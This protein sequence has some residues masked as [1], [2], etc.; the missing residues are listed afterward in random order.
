MMTTGRGRST[1]D[2]EGGLM[3]RLGQWLAMVGLILS[4][5]GCGSL[6]LYSKE[7]DVAATSAKSDY[8]ASKVTQ[9]I[10]AEGAM[11]DGLD[12]KEIEAFRKVT[13]AERNL[14]L[15]SLV[16]ESGTSAK[17]S[18]AN[19]LV[20]RFR[21]LADAR[22]IALTGP[23]TDP[24]QFLKELNNRKG[25]LRDA[26]SNEIRAR[27]QLI[28]FHAKFALL[29]ACNQDVAGLKANPSAD[30]AAALTKDA[31]FQ[32][33]NI[34]VSVTWGIAIGNLGAA[35]EALLDARV[36]MAASLQ[37][38]NAAQVGL[39]MSA[40]NDQEALLGRKQ[41]DAKA[42]GAALRSA[43]KA[44]ADARNA[45]QSASQGIDL[46][47]DP[48]KAATPPPAGADEVQKAKGAL[49]DALAKLT[50]LG[51]F[52][53]RIISQERLAR[54][55]TVLAA[56]SGIEPAAGDP[57]LEPSLALLGAGSR[58]A[59]ALKQYQTAGTL[60]ALEPLLIEKQLAAAQLAY[61][62]AGVAL[63]QARVRH[64]QAYR[65]AT[66]LEVDLLV[67][68]R[69]ELGALGAVPAA[70]TDCTKVA[71]VFC[72]SMNQLLTDKTFSGGPGESASRR[73]YR[74]MALLSESYSVARDRQLTAELSLIDTDYR[75][76]ML[77]SNASIAA[78]NALISV[79]VDQ[80]KAYHA[81][82]WTPQEMAQLLQ[83]FGVVGVA[84]RIK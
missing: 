63:A 9:A 15:L 72:A 69:A 65:D 61:A 30:A 26:E 36:A 13:L 51:D 45:A 7:A 27:S 32:P 75:D 39:A 47:C 82:G 8:D 84:A 49:C 10:Q 23:S 16:S 48:S 18:T 20:P 37:K 80:L 12:A 71:A 64:A 19:G 83:A 31:D 62:Q 43:A 46:T 1:I 60:P 53:A 77:R 35:C 14:E 2:V 74:A 50:N 78:W 28:A 38:A 25:T 3:K 70:D 34:P 81:D 41:A 42:Q 57:P 76:S 55:N 40:A 54:I 24:L 17:R 73:A 21:Q 33:K 68:A 4:L 56:L 11:L 22:L 66:F 44:L 29:P 67:K 59:Q 52:G 5:G 6:H 58:F 79:P